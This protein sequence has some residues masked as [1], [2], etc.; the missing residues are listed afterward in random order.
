MRAAAP[1]RSSPVRPTSSRIWLQGLLCGTLIAVAAPAALLLAVLG[2]PALL[3]WLFDR[4]PGRPMA[5]NLALA[6]AA[7]SLPALAALWHAGH[8]WAACLDLLADPSRLAL[9]WALQAG[10]WL[11]GELAPLAARLALDAAAAAQATRLR[12]R[13]AEYEREWGLR[14]A[15]DDPP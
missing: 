4:A 7:A 12:A 5:R 13:R 11:L 2:L 14:Q 3:A 15:G 6:A 9:A 10:F 8:N 1:Q